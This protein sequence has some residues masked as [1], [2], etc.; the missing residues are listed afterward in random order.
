MRSSMRVCSRSSP[1]AAASYAAKL[2]G[3]LRD[4]GAT[5][6][7]RDARLDQRRDDGAGG[8]GGAHE[9]RSCRSPR[10]SASRASQCATRSG[11]ALHQRLVHDRQPHG[12]G[13]VDR[14]Q[15][16][17]HDVGLEQLHG[18]E[19]AGV[20]QL[21]QRGRERDARGDPD[22]RLQRRRHD[23]GQ[24]DVL[25]DP[26]AGAHA[27]E[28]LHLEHRHVGGLELAH[29]VGV[30]GPADRLV[31][32]DGY[33]DGPAYPRQVLDGG[34]RLL[35]VLEP[36]RGPVEHRDVRHGGVQ[37]PEPVDVDAHPAVG[38][39]R[40]AHGF[41]AGLV[42]G[43]GLP[44]FGDLDLGGAAAAA[45]HDRV[46]LLGADRGDGDV[47]RHARRA[48]ETASHRRRPPPRSAATARATAASYSRNGL[49][50]PHP[51]GPAD[52][53]RPRAR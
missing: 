29:P 45:Q 14:E 32:G 46:R 38:A 19:P 7:S 15:R 37:V 44:G 17:G 27:T 26:Q 39:E 31:G 33:A 8:V 47:D 18:R 40:V 12:Q 34:D 13:T 16:L 6:T 49:H 50:S 48:R 22:R 3:A 20:R 53:A 9:R 10:T 5:T 36:A 11:D 43:E 4:P 35:D 42:V 1:A 51:A 21:R 2:S 23:H 30:G 25:G 24:P 41:E 28:R 52:A